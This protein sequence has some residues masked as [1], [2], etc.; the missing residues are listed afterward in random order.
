MSAVPKPQYVRRQ[1]Q[2]TW[3][4]AQRAEQARKLNARQIWRKST[5]P[6]TWQGKR[7]SSQNALKSGK[8]S[9]ETKSIRTWLCFISR[10]LKN[11]KAAL[12][13]HDFTKRYARK[14][15]S[16]NERGEEAEQ[17]P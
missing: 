8:F 9:A 10:N 14:I 16:Q 7:I 12:R 11:I 13:H 2:R 3:T 17:G 1:G 4:D 6:R 5:G 15:F